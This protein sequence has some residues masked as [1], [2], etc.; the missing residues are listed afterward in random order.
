MGGVVA[1][2]FVGLCSLLHLQL[3][4]ASF[5]ML[6]SL[7]EF[8]SK[9]VLLAVAAVMRRVVSLL[10]G[11]AEG[12]L[13]VADDGTS[14]TKG[15]LA[16]KLERDL[17]GEGAGEEVPDRFLRISALDRVLDLYLSDR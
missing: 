10:V 13:A 3:R 16:A 14:S 17:T 9:P 1:P 12:A 2:G 11:A 15:A 7:S 8:T 4:R 5:E 6:A